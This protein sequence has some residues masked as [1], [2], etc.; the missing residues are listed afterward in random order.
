MGFYKHLSHKLSEFDLLACLTV[1]AFAIAIVI[2]VFFFFSFPSRHFFWTDC[3]KLFSQ[4]FKFNYKKTCDQDLTHSLDTLKYISV[5][6]V[7]KGVIRNTCGTWYALCTVTSI[8][9][10]QRNTRNFQKN[11]PPGQKLGNKLYWQLVD[12]RRFKGQNREKFV[13]EQISLENA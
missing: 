7:M 4:C 8:Y 13:E 5:K 9:S 3:Q 2:L 12:D 11:R 10:I 6:I 1:F